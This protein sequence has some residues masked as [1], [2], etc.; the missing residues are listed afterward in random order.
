MAGKHGWRRAALAVM[1]VAAAAP[2]ALPASSAWAAGEAEG[3]QQAGAAAAAGI[4][5][6][7]SDR[8]PALKTNEVTGDFLGLG[9]DQRAVLEEYVPKD[10]SVKLRIY[11]RS[12]IKLRESTLQIGEWTPKLL[13]G[14]LA[15]QG[16]AAHAGLTGVKIAAG[17][18][19]HLYVAGYGKINS[20]LSATAI[21]KIDPRPA[22]MKQT[23]IRIPD[24]VSVEGMHG[25]LFPIITS[26]DVGVV[27][28]VETLAAGQSAGGVRFYSMEDLG[29]RGAM[30]EDWNRSSHGGWGRDLVT[31]VKFSGA[32]AVR[33][34][35]GAQVTG[36]AVGRLTYDVEQHSTHSLYMTDPAAKKTLWQD[37]ESAHYGSGEMKSPVAF[38]FDDDNG[39]LAVSW[40][41]EK[42]DDD[43][44]RREPLE[45]RDAASGAVQQTEPQTGDQLL[46]PSARLSYVKSGSNGESHLIF[47]ARGG[48]E[49]QVFRKGEGDRL[50][51][52]A[53]SGGRYA[54]DDAAVRAWFPG[55]RSVK[56][57]IK[58][59]SGEPI[60]ARLVSNSQAEYRGC[61]NNTG[62]GSATPFPSG[63]FARVE[64]GGQTA[65]HSSAVLT[66]GPSGTC[67]QPESRYSYVEIQPAGKPGLRS[68]VKI[69]DQS[70]G[71]GIAFPEQ[72]GGGALKITAEPKGGG[73]LGEHQLTVSGAG[74]PQAVRA[75]QVTAKRLTTTSAD[76]DAGRPVYRF[77]VS[78]AAWQVPG[79]DTSL[80]ETQ[81][82]A[83]TA[84]GT[85]NGL[86]WEDLGLLKPVTA[87]R[88]DGDTITL[89]KT[90]F[91]WENE[92]NATQY[93][94]IRVKSGVK[95]SQPVTLKDLPAPAALPEKVTAVKFVS[96]PTGKSVKGMR[97]NGIDQ[98]FFEI[99]ISTPSTDA[100]APD[101]EAYDRLFYR[102]NPDRRLITGLIDPERPRQFTGITED[103]GAYPNDGGSSVM[104]TA[105]PERFRSY[106]TTTNTMSFGVT[107]YVQDSGALPPTDFSVFPTNQEPRTAPL[108]G[109]GVA[110]TDMAC[111]EGVCSIADPAKGPVLYNAGS[112]AIGIQLRARAIT[113]SASLP[114]VH[115]HERDGVLTP[116]G[117]LSEMK[118]S[119]S[120]SS[121]AHLDGAAG[122]AESFHGA[123]VTHGDYLEVT[124]FRPQG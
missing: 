119:V 100:L 81:L 91:Y 101:N 116:S 17:K 64:P 13:A 12:G 10:Y 5:V 85:V 4:A 89:G 110:V 79:A 66:S 112:P 41:H 37:V 80:T 70:G 56:L 60:E 102:T 21:L 55:Y 7:E 26:L 115:E 62:V 90:S 59:N 121:T 105:G 38:A 20:E 3:E 108:Q 31:A 122:G 1:A 45:V 61:W 96:D 95:A 82:P 75:P 47:G 109:G 114:M 67:A 71:K 58:N 32:G 118:V 76:G 87:P 39:R 50:S 49:N 19:G 72:A 99:A 88:Q 86:V 113:G 11:D 94:K 54:G 2:L 30:F 117:F 9:Y 28:G 57:N 73:G 8:L 68:I 53:L 124:D 84:Q 15:H 27:D 33:T 46:G 52:I 16:W 103:R 22:E 24:L 92:K 29:P 63:S 93:T 97:S 25:G 78:D 65:T 107:G 44:S 48:Q 106:L 74:A 35:D 69:Q 104:R 36:L 23:G 6:D 51:P 123:V 77:D 43:E 34:P 40:W 83:M 111:R 120:N 98:G 18:N 42:H 14:V